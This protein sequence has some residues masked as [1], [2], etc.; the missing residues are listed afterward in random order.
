LF[1]NYNRFEQKGKKTTKRKNE[2]EPLTFALVLNRTPVDLWLTEAFYYPELSR[3]FWFFQRDPNITQNLEASSLTFLSCGE[4]HLSR[5]FVLYVYEDG[6][7]APSVLLLEDSNVRWLCAVVD[8][9]IIVP[10]RSILE[11]NHAN[12]N[13]GGNGVLSRALLQLSR[14]LGLT[15]KLI[16]NDKE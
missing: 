14:S 12:S 11:N 16:S 8:R 1:T 13:G 15:P 4:T 2:A 9:W 5:R 7:Q 6:G 10:Y 3:L